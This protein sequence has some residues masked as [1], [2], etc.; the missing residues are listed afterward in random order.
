MKCAI[1]KLLMK[2]SFFIF[3]VIVPL[4]IGAIIYYVFFPETIFVKC[5]DKLLDISYHIPLKPENVFAKGIRF[6]FLDFL[7][8]YALMSFVVWL[9]GYERKIVIMIVLFEV[10]MELVQLFP[11][12]KGTFDVCDIG[13]EIIANIPVILFSRRGFNN[14]KDESNRIDGDHACI[15]DDVTRK[16]FKHRY[17]NKRDC[18]RQ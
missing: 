12:I 3:N 4:L 5:L 2:K 18:D 6:Y 1:I 14:E 8:A 10:L 9:F 17:R 11:G 7:W 13:I 15:W 16:R